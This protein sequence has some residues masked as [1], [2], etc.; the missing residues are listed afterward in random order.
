MN[1]KNN[2]IK[3]NKNKII[4][5]KRKIIKNNKYKFQIYKH[6]KININKIKK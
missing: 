5:I 2:K 1:K 4:K 3:K 6:Y